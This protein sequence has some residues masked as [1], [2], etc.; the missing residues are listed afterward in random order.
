M[1]K[2]KKNKRTLIR[3]VVIIGVIIIPLLYSWLYLGAFWDPYSKLDEL[4]VAVVNLDKGAQI[5]GKQMNLGNDMCDKLKEDGTLKFIFTDN[6]TAQEGIK[7]KSYY[8]TIT[9]PEDFSSCIASASTSDKHVAEISFLSNEKRNYLASQIL[10]KAVLQIESEVRGDVNYEIVAQLCDQ[11]K[12]TPDQLTGLVDGLGE[13][14]DGSQNIKDGT[15]NLTD[16]TLQLKNGSAQL[17]QKASEFS[18]GVNTAK[19]SAAQLLAGTKELENGINKVTQGANQLDSATQNIDELRT[20]AKV[21]ADSCNSFNQGMIQYTDGVSSLISSAESTS[22]FLINY[23]KSN[24]SIM[25][26]PTFAAFVKQ[27]SNPA[28][29]QNITALKGYT[30]QLQ[31]ASAQIAAGTKLLSDAT[32]DIPSL[33]AGISQLTAGLKSVQNG[34]SQVANGAGQ[35]KNGLGQLYSASSQINNATNKLAQGAEKVDS[36]AG[37]LDS[38]AQQLND[39]IHN[40]KNEVNN[41]INST[42][43]KLA[44][45]DGLPDFAKAPVVKNEG[46]VYPVPNYGTAFAPYFLCLSL[47]V[48]ALIIFF[49]IYLDADN[50]FKILSRSSEHKILRC[51]IYLLIGFVQAIVLGVVLKYCLGLTINNQLLYYFSICLFS[52]VSISIVQFLLVF[53]KDAGKFLAIVMLILQLTS[54]GGT[55]PMETVPK[56]FNILYPFMPMTYAVNLLKEAISGTASTFALQNVLVLLGILIFFVA[57]TIVCGLIKNKKPVHQLAEN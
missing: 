28:N 31:T 45:L 14:S 50:K 3:C 56:F 47:W 10:S 30:K 7:A 53:F 20:N 1:E 21:L 16:G 22:A 41:T 9:I 17:N 49:G 12:S 2:L 42:Q 52:L 5:N 54:C 33:K 11:L 13:L 34:A 44:S 6:Q 43:D 19:N 39:G 40:A 15:A 46:A 8:A 38:G 23:V 4:A 26:E 48:G 36:G 25:Q 35:L 27:L 55:F 57:L 51:V 24:P 37:A 18:S 32:L 29:A